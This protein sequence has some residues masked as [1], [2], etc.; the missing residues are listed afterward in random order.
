MRNLKAKTLLHFVRRTLIIR[1]LLAA[2][3][4]SLMVGLISYQ[5]NI[6]SIKISVEGIA[7]ERYQLLKNKTLSI[8]KQSNIPLK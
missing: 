3:F 7:S 6:S 5:I 8:V 4:L 2:V 1:L